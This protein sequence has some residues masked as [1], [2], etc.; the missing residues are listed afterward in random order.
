[1]TDGANPDSG[2]PPWAEATKLV[3][4]GLNRSMFGETA[5][6]IYLT[7]GYVYG[8]ASEAEAAFRGETDHHI[9]SRY[10]NP[11][12]ATFEERLR[13]L[14]GAQACRATASG[15]AAVFAAI[16]SVVSAG[17]RL[18]AS[19]ALFGSCHVV[20]T[21]IMPRFGVESV[22]VDGTNLDQWEQALTPGTKAV[23]LETPSNPGLEVVD[24]AKVCE[25]AHAVG[26]LVIVDN[27]FATPILQK[28]MEHGADVV[29]YSATKHIDGQGRTLGGAVLASEMFVAEYLQPFLRH[30]GPCMSPFNAW[31]LTK[32]LETL[33]IRV[34]AQTQQAHTLAKRLSQHQQTNAVIYPGLDNHPQAEIIRRQMT[35]GGT[36]I[37]LDIAGGKEAAF[38]ALDNLKIFDISNNLGDAKSLATHPATTTHSRLSPEQREQ[39]GIRPG[40]VRLSVGLEDV[41]DLW[42]D[43]DQALCATSHA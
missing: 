14:E 23:F 19:R 7:S 8:S 29:V 11:T 34:E 18:V 31:T 22:L 37:T 17:D 16:A 9:Y 38:C 1:M 41:D 26:A 20:V 3:R 30:T 10:S 21:E 27:V 39:A 2:P 24:L 25:L 32:G 6:P 40:T 4:A 15:M 5:E 28:P 33:R 35:G 13:Q 36:I 43:L 12:V 42:N